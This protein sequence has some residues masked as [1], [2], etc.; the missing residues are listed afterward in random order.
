MIKFNPPFSI[1]KLAGV[2]P[3]C[4]IQ[5]GDKYGF[6]A[7][8]ASDTEQPRTALL[9]DRQKGAFEHL[10]GK[11]PRVINFGSDLTIVPDMKAYEASLKPSAKTTTE[12]FIYEKVPKLSLALAGDMYFFDLNSG[13]YAEAPLVTPAA[14]L[15]WIVGVTTPSGDFF[16]LMDV[17]KPIPPPGFTHATHMGR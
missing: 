7:V 16:E 5:M 6:S 9:Y 13:T 8:S 4:L 10:S 1:D 15:G 11:N 3:G 14:F 2:T 17:A 12:L